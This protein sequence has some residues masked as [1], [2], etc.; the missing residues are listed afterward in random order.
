MKENMKERDFGPVRFIPGENQGRYPF[1]HSIYLKGPGVLIDPASDREKLLKL[2]KN[3]SVKEVWL[4]HWHEDHLMHLDLFDDLPLCISEPDAAPL[5]DLD[6]FMDA[7][8][9]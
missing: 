7:M 3:S 2:K 8:G 9:R 5:S 1:C 6:L 4:S